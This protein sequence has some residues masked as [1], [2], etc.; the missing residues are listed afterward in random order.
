[1]AKIKCTNCN[2]L[3]EILS[4]SVNQLCQNCGEPILRGEEHFPNE[5]ADQ[6]EVEL[7]LDKVYQPESAKENMPDR[8]IV[9]RT[10]VP[11][12]DPTPDPTP[13]K[14]VK[15]I[16]SED[17]KKSK[18]DL[19]GWLVV[20]DE[21]KQELTF[22][23]FVGDNFFGKKG[24]G[25]EVDILIDNDPYVSRSHANI[26]ISKDFLNRF[27]CQLLDDGSRRSKGPSLNGTFVN[28]NTERLP[29]ETSVFL[30][31]GDTIQ[32]GETKLVFKS[33]EKFHNMEEAADEVR[34]SDYTSTVIFRK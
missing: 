9:E 19:A 7:N 18:E 30:R 17:L 33:V 12:P 1:M 28:G 2:T 32:I 4:E 14:A 29:K 26:R 21:N 15:K 23:L 5:S 10:P 11:D 31:D 20:H 16:I 6:E 8:T 3:T 24:E 13:K 25:F 27:H 22:D 34:K